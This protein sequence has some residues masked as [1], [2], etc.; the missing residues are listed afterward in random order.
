M[1]PLGFTRYSVMPY[2]GR[3]SDTTC[4]ADRAALSAGQREASW[5]A[6]DREACCFR[7]YAYAP[8]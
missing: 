1:M 5:S 6:G 4:Y 2:Q 7:P 8:L 3:V